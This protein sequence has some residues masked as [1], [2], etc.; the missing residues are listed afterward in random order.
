MNEPTFWQLVEAARAECT[1][2]LSNQPEILQKR[3]EALPPSEIVEF[4][5]IFETLLVKAYRWDLWAAG[6]IIE[7]GCSDDG[8]SDFRAGLIG[9]GRDVFYDA[10][11]DAG[12]LIRQPTRGVDFSH[13]DMLYVARKAYT[14]VTGTEMPDQNVSRPDEPAGEPW[15]EE[16]VGEKYP[17]LAKKFGFK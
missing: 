7:G 15:D 8:F 10:I 13:E 9:F 16:S 12:T 3:L 1:P 11:R 6:Y 5:K 14:S 2:E 17:E 4:G